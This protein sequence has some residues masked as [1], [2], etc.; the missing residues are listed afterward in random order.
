MNL[1]ILFF[2]LFLTCQTVAA[3]PLYVSIEL[4]EESRLLILT[5]DGAVRLA[6]LD[7]GHEE[8]D[9]DQVGFANPKISEDKTMVGWLSLYPNCC[10]SYPIPLEVVLQQNGKV[11]AKF[12]GNGLPIWQW[13]FRGASRQIALRQSPTH[14]P[15]PDHYE[16]RDIQ[17]GKLLSE[18]DPEEQGALQGAPEWALGLE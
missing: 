5:E 1:S 9:K 13:G 17:T 16:L 3:S 2:A 14:G 10:T 18:F 8:T 7:T 11:I 6:P 4:P 15:N 12:R